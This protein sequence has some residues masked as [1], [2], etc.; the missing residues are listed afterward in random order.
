MVSQHGAD[1]RNFHAVVVKRSGSMAEHAAD[2]FRIRPRKSLPHCRCQRLTVAL[3]RSDVPGVSA[4][5]GSGHSNRKFSAPGGKDHNSGRFAEIQSGP[6]P[7]IRP[8]PFRAHRPEGV[9]TG[10]CKF[11]DQIARRDNHLFRH[12][13]GNHPVRPVQRHAR[14]R[15]RSGDN[16]AVGFPEALPYALQ[17]G[18]QCIRLIRRKTVDLSHR[19]CQQKRCLLRQIPDGL[20]KKFDHRPA[21][22]LLLPPFP[23]LRSRNDRGF[24]ACKKIDRKTADRG[25]RRFPAEHRFLREFLSEP[26]AADQFRVCQKNVTHG[27]RP[28]STVPGTVPRLP[29]G[30]RALLLSADP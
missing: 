17:Q 8:R 16:A 19:A 22:G 5:P 27:I 9:K 1:R 4:H 2:G 25:K 18:M 29:A 23:L 12:S 7:V 20:R 6:V 28:F 24:G 30:S 21:E 15:A 13:F 14:R 26:E 3:R 10:K 11:A